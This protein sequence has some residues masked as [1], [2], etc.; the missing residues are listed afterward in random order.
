MN[1]LFFPQYKQNISKYILLLTHTGEYSFVMQK[2]RKC[3]INW[4]MLKIF[5]KS[6][7]RSFFN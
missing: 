1:E 4:A 5:D 2:E 6:S 7:D 3:M